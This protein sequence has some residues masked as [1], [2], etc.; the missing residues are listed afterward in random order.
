VSA[1]AAF[2]AGVAL[3][4]AILLGAE[5]LRRHGAEQPP[6]RCAR[7]GEGFLTVDDVVEHVAQHRGRA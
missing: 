6:Y 1:L 3:G 5:L 7:C 4:V 2:A